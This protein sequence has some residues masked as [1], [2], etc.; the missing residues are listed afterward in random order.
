[1]AFTWA[2][3]ANT[4]GAGIPLNNTRTPARV[5]VTMPLTTCI[6]TGAP[7]PRFL[8]TM[9]IN[10]PG[11]ILPPSRLAAFSTPDSENSGTGGAKA[12]LVA[13]QPDNVPLR[14]ESR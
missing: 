2:E 7:G 9:V 13:G 3:E 6:P 4:T 10:S 8:P 11:A 5:V 14:Y 12:G 1:M